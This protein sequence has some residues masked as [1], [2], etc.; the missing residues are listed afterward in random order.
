MEELHENEI[1]K[2]RYI[3]AALLNVTKEFQLRCRNIKVWIWI[4]LI[5]IFLF[6]NHIISII[7]CT[8][9]IILSIIYYLTEVYDYF[10]LY[11][12][13]IKYYPKGIIIKYNSKGFQKQDYFKYT[14]DFIEWNNFSIGFHN[15]SIGN[16]ALY[17][18][19]TKGYHLFFKTEGNEK[20]FEMFLR[21]VKSKIRIV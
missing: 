14:W 11:K 12:A 5:V 7:V 6:I 20:E 19:K 21:I 9:L 3:W 13:R 16:I 15:S 2:G 17:N 8:I 18:T 10:V 1:E 4:T